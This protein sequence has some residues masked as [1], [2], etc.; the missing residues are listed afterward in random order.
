MT[1]PELE[2]LKL[3]RRGPVGWLI[4][5]RPDQL[6][7]MS[8]RMRHEFAVAWTELDR[9]GPARVGETLLERAPQRPLRGPHRRG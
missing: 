5:N 2:C 4:N 7:A 1:Y 8:A 3:E 6:N 9:P